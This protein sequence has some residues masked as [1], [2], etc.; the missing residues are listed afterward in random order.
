M[1]T[2]NSNYSGGIGFT[3]LLT[4]IF[5]V[6]KLLGKLDWSWWWVFSPL[7]IS[8]GVAFVVILA[9]LIVAIIGK[10]LD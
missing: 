7:W 2:Q 6:F 5:V 4:C 9:I 10:F 8:T 1:A 3:G